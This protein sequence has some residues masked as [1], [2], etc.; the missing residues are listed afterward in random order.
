MA[1]VMR[2][3]ASRAMKTGLRKWVLGGSS[4]AGLGLRTSVASCAL[5]CKDA[6]CAAALAENAAEE[7]W[8]V[9]AGDLDVEETE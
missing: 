7:A 8:R 2:S 5:R 1:I 6:A 9:T 3:V 4:L